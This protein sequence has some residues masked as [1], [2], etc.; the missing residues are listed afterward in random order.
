[1]L[2]RERQALDQI[3]ADTAAMEQPER[4]AYLRANRHLVEIVLECSESRVHWMLDRLYGERAQ[5]SYIRD[6]IENFNYYMTMRQTEL[7]VRELSAIFGGTAISGELDRAHKKYCI[8]FRRLAR[9][10]R[11]A[12]K[13]ARRKA[14][15][16]CR[17]HWP[18]TFAARGDEAHP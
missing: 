10:S 3:K 15:T 7:S 6:C 14:H 8:D 13:P 11:K 18:K 16:T 5:L 1:M 9:K 2:T 4:M 17:S 12:R